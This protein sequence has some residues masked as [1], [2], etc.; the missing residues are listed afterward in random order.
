MNNEQELLQN[1]I[2]TNGV[3]QGTN[4]GNYNNLLNNTIKG[5]KAKIA[6]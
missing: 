4:R 5:V 2:D 6:F 1:L 3:I